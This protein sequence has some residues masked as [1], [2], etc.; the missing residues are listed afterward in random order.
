[1]RGQDYAGEVEHLVIDGGSTDG[2]LD[3]LAAAGVRYVSEPDRGLSDGVN[4]GIRMAQGDVIGWLNADDV[5]LPG[6][7]S[8]V[9]KAFVHRSDALWATGPCLIMGADGEEIRSSVTPYK[10]FFPRRYSYRLHLVRNF[11]SCASTFIR[12]EAFDR[13][14]LIEERFAYLDGLRSLAAARAPLA[15]AGPGRAAAARC[16]GSAGARTR[17]P[18]NGGKRRRHEAQDF[19]AR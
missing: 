4:K 15:S 18:H 12:R 2:T 13:V 16:D 8:R 9:G 17:R 5:Y 7:L 1:M 19:R 3:I 14:G 11:V 10:N 6:A